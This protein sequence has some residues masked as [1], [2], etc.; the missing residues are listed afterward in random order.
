MTANF[1]AFIRKCKCCEG[2]A[3]CPSCATCASTRFIQLSNWQWKINAAS[4]STFTIVQATAV[5]NKNSGCNYSVT[6]GAVTCSALQNATP[7]GCSVISG[8]GLSCSVP[9]QCP[10]PG[11]IAQWNINF[12]VFI[13]PPQNIVA[14]SSWGVA[15][16]STHSCHATG[17][18]VFCGQQIAGGPGFLVNAGT[19]SLS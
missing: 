7:I 2:F 19:C 1:M 18:Y 13:G 3:T 17:S 10:L 8:T 14:N 5:V 15:V 11:A 9:F 16:L 4:P 12:N 6:V